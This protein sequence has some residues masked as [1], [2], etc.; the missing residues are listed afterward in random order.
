MGQPSLR[1][2]MGLRFKQFREMIDKTQVELGEEFNVYQS[3]ITNIEV[4]K[5]FPGVKYLHHMGKVYGLNADWLVNERG[6][7]FYDPLAITPSMYHK[8]KEMMHLMQI[9]V[10]EQL[11]LARLQEVKVIAKEEIAAFL[12]LP[13]KKRSNRSSK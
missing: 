4:G 13:P 2:E 10:V 7:A 12:G 3:T 6:E 9:P 11:M 8:Y 5:T 1:K